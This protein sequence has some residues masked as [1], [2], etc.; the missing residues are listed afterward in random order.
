MS[1]NA[2]DNTIR[3]NIIGVSPLGQ[4]APVGRWGIA[5]REN[6]R[7]HLI[8]GNVIRNANTGGNNTGGGIGLRQ[9]DVRY[10]KI[11]RNIISNTPGP[12]IYLAPYP[13][14]PSSG[15][16]DLLAS[17]VITSATT[18]KVSGTGIAGATVEV[19]RADRPAGQ[20][21]LP[22]ELCR[23]SNSRRQRNVASPI[24]LERRPGRDRPSDHPQP[25]HLAA[26]HQCGHHF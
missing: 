3:N 11:T 24:S 9:P 5:V 14:D 19:Y 22:I 16:N 18:V 21:G 20:S 2:T 1:S 25:E 4:A 17:P 23:L 10:I 6:T 7:T 26:G 15:A 8:E 13:N 12:A